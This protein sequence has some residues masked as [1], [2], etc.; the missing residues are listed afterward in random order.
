METSSGMTLDDALVK[1]RWQCCSYAS[2]ESSGWL[3]SSRLSSTP[4]LRIAVRVLSIAFRIVAAPT[5]CGPLP[6]PVDQCVNDA[7]RSTLDALA[8]C[9]ASCISDQTGLSIACTGCYGY[10]AA[11]ATS[12][13]IAPCLPPKSGSP[14]CAA[15]G[16]EN[17]INLEACTGLDWA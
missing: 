14:D 15:C 13:C 2:N 1:L 5:P 11:R 7:D 3:S 10:T 16:V 9:I 12:F 4:M 6:G 17:C 8:T